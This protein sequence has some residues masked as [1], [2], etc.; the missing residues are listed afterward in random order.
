MRKIGR[1][2]HKIARSGFIGEFQVFAPAES[3]AAFDDVE[4]RLKIAVM[5]RAGLGI[6]LDGDGSGP[7]LRGAGARVID[8]CGPR[9]AYE[10]AACWYPVRVSE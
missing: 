10:S 9:H 3:R 7:D 6:G 1:N 8:G 5:M 4:H 2:K